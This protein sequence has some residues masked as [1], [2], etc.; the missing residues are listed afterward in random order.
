MSGTFLRHR[1]V[2][3]S[4]LRVT[5]AACCGLGAAFAQ[6]EPDPA[7]AAF[8]ESKVRPLLSKHCY[9]C[10]S[11]RAEKVKGGLLLDTREGWQAGG[12]SGDVLVPGNPDESLL[13]ESVRYRNPDL[14]MPPK[15]KL[16]EDEIEV[17]EHWVSL[18]APDP[19]SGAPKAAAKPSGIDPEQGK[20]HWAFRPVTPPAVPPVRDAAWPRDD[21]DRFILARIE[22]AGLRPVPDAD[23]FTLL[24]RVCLDLTG[25]PPSPEEV[26]AFA[27][28]PA[29]DDVALAR[30][31]D[32][33]L[34]TPAF[35]ERWGRHWLDV[36]R[37]ADSVGK[38]RNVPFPYAW[39]YRNHVIDAVNAD[40][41][42][43]AFL[44]EQIAGDLLDSGTEDERR[45]RL[46]ASGWL[47]LG[48]MDL[49]ERDK[50][51]FSLDRIDDQVDTLG[52][53]TM[54][55]TL[56]CARCHDHKFDPVA[57]TDYY[58]LAGIFASTRTLSGQTNRA[59]GQPRVYHD[60]RLLASLGGPGG[61]A[62]PGPGAD[63]LEDRL[64]ELRARMKSKQLGEKERRALYAEMA[65][66]RLHLEV[67]RPDPK[68]ASK[69]KTARN[70][71]A[72]QPDPDAPL[73]MSAMDGPIM[74]LAL[75][76]RGEPD[77]EGDVVPRGFPA[78]L[79]HGETPELPEDA[80]GRLELARWLVSREHP[81]TARVMANRV[82]GHLFGRGIVE[83]VD[84]FGLSGAAP[85]H[86][87][88]LDHLAVRFVD[89]GWSV[90]SLVRSLVLSRT[91]R[92]AVAYP[93]ANVAADEGNALFWRAH[94]RRLEAEAIRDS[95]LAAAGTLD[96]DRPE[97]AP[98]DRSVG[99]D[100]AKVNNRRA[101]AASDVIARPVR[102][103]YLPVFR[104]RL[105][106]MFTVFDFAEPD[107]V[108]G[109]R[110]VTTVPT[111]ALFFLNNPFV[112]SAARSTADRL[113]QPAAADDA[114]RVREAYARVLGRFPTPEE[115]ARALDYVARD[116][117]GAGW[118]AFVQAL[119]SS[120]EFRYIP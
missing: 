120:A 102:S 63:E 34:A 86:P 82:W 22:A 91:Y 66:L 96:L 7:H 58:A 116:P 57:Q 15:Y 88:L 97:G 106:G 95:V 92:L 47:A 48:S 30:V 8:F 72:P 39:R 20:R 59:G 50:V 37:Y 43:D 26:A 113:L 101:G 60:P 14:Q 114:T 80:S 107:Q 11:A 84:N 1:A 75:R 6:T 61:G 28:D 94:L 109:R 68:A 79:V 108:N 73:A 103:V 55:L 56:G 112:V 54:G 49:N 85:T 41:P 13:V 77:L 98:F 76:V 93:A 83:T 78:I 2:S 29:S 21:A 53:A 10:H 81:L 44:T 52:R 117:G 119:F 46:V 64:Q 19:R 100:L 69:K 35:G 38:T 70:E 17:L 5:L 62:G 16:S 25:L 4:L 9:D 71:K 74:D 40:Q 51:Q 104:S 32:R 27:S 89:G 31:V 24:R 118:A 99:A 90:K 87:E 36:A 111:Q 105:P 45:R 42:Y 18:G 110:D 65:E 23:R 33:L 67:L 115:S 12:D 3:A